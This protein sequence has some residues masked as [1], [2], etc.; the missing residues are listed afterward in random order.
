MINELHW[1]WHVLFCPFIGY[2]PVDP[3]IITDPLTLVLA[4][5][6]TCGWTTYAGN[7]NLEADARKEL[8]ASK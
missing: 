5:C 7:Y 4:K 2:V 6:R 8:N 3:K 1:L